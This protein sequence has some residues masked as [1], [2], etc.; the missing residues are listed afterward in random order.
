VLQGWASK[1]WPAFV[2]AAAAI[3]VGVGIA[4]VVVKKRFS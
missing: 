3:A 4:V 1:Y 2:G